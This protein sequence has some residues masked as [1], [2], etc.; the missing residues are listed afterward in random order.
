MKPLEGIVV[1]DFSQYLA[2]PSCSLRLADLGARVIKIERP[3]SGDNCRRTILKNMVIEDDSLLFHT[4]NRSKESYCANMKDP[5]DLKILKMLIKKADV[6]IENFRPGVMKK[7]GLDYENVRGINPRIVYGTITGYGDKGPW[8]KKPGQDLVVQSMSGLTW[9]NGNGG[10]PPT[11]FGL[12]VVDS[13]TGV[14][15]AEGILAALYRR[16]KTGRGAQ[17]QVSLMESALDMQFEG[18]TA[19]LNGGKK[20]PVRAEYNNAHPYLAAPYGI[21]RTRDGC[22][23]LSQGSLKD[24][25]S[26]L[27]LPEL[28]EYGPGD[29]FGKRDEI[30]KLI[31][32]RLIQQTTNHWLAILEKEDYWCCE[33]YTWEKMLE[34]E[35]FKE[36]KFLQTL[37][38]SDGREIVTSR[39]P[40]KVDGE[41]YYSRRPG[42]KLGADTEK[43]RQEIGEVEA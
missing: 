18:I 22:I 29:E 36:L 6:M 9:L 1:L 13:Y 28:N 24:L 3:G 34:S 41:A 15:L 27:E 26:Y 31:G 10:N 37:E 35:G 5:D 12:S 25:A 17:V 20:L 23:A 16:I 11:P 4:I 33:V 43:I 21:D 30:K 8:A 32:S 19:Y 2:G 40:I 39:C 14:H 38:L 7:N 42:P